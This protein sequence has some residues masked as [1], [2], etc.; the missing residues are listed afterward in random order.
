MDIGDTVSIHDDNRMQIGTATVLHSTDYGTI[1]EVGPVHLLADHATEFC[2]RH[3]KVRPGDRVAEPGCGTGVLSL[4]C[5]RAGAGHVTGTDIDRVALEAAGQNAKRNGI[6]NVSFIEG[7]LLDPVSGPLDLVVALLPHKPAPRPFNVRYFGGADGTDLL[8]AVIDKASRLL[9]R[10]GRLVLY[11]NSIANP[12]RVLE[13]L[14]RHFRIRPLAE[15]HRPF[16]QEE[17]DQLTPGM[18]EHLSALRRRGQAEFYEESGRMYF[19]ARIYEGIR[20]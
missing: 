20:R 4:Y 9:V 16:S 14:D 13:A 8:L 6:D 12:P 1:E 7:N 15:K 10:R 11:H 3:L 18:F 2:L 17:F 5:A 19:L